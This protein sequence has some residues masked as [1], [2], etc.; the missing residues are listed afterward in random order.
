MRG[1]AAS[2]RP[3][4]EDRVEWLLQQEQRQLQGVSVEQQL[5][6]C[7]AAAGGADAAERL[8]W[9]AGRGFPVASSQA[10]CEAVAHGRTE[11]V[12]YLV[13]ELGVELERWAGKEAMRQAACSGHRYV[14]EALRERGY[15]VPSSAAEGAV[16]EGHVH[17][18]EWVLGVLPGPAWCHLTP[19]AFIQ[20]V[21]WEEWPMLQLLLR[22]RCRASGTLR[23]RRGPRRRPWSGWATATASTTR[24][25]SWRLGRRAPRLQRSTPQVRPTTRSCGR[26]GGGGGG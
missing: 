23:S 21:L 6:A 14:L 17:V 15:D 2:H 25:R 9:L 4:W 18:A 7:V 19:A 1:A 20:A 11:A 13:D 26:R 16:R 24:W 12:V 5:G 10:A 8:R 3:D 22:A